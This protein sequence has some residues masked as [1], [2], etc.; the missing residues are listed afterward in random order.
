MNL[1][2]RSITYTTD[3]LRGWRLWQRHDYNSCI[4]NKRFH[5]GDYKVLKNASHEAVHTPHNTPS[6]QGV[7]QSRSRRHFHTNAIDA[8]NSF[9][10]AG[11]SRGEQSSTRISRKPTQFRSLSKAGGVRV[12]FKSKDQSWASGYGPIQAASKDLVEKGYGRNPGDTRVKK[13]V[14]QRGRLNVANIKP[15]KHDEKSKDALDKNCELLQKEQGKSSPE[16]QDTAISHKSAQFRERTL[17]SLG[18]AA[19]SIRV[20]YDIVA[21]EDES[22]PELIYQIPETVMTTA[23]MT[24]AP[25]LGAYWSHKL[26]KSTKGEAVKI[27]YCR[28]QETSETVA[29]SF[30]SSLSSLSGPKIIGF[31]LEWEV[32]SQPGISPIQECVSLLQL[33]T[34]SRIAVF[35]LAAFRYPPVPHQDPP[36]SFLPSSLRLLLERDDIIKCGVNISADFTRLFK[37]LDIQGQGI[38]ELSRLYRIVTFS[39]TRPELVNKSLVKLGTQV[40]NVL[41]LPMM[42]DSGVRM[43]KWSKKLSAEQ[44]DYAAADAYAGFRLWSEL[45]RRRRDM[46]TDVE[47]PENGDE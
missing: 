27:H 8:A 39:K 11:W 43:S 3:L 29:A 25:S 41:G 40:E 35:H 13:E 23:L 22:L 19:T 10:S 31:D 24:S 44:I 18:S 17:E 21:R 37:T 16:A 7:C 45:E 6:T 33:A 1:S 9:S 2:A 47:I 14:E 26:Y 30:L 28:S 5:A 34:E 38:C 12:S 42:K 32:G 15:P 46:E 36:H 4:L 20:N